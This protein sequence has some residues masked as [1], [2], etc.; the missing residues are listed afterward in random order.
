MLEIELPLTRKQE[1]EA[2][3]VGLMMMAEACYD[4]RAAVGLWQRMEILQSMRR[5]RPPPEFLSTH[6]AVSFP[7]L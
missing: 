6:P 4:P 3:Y 2:D 1:I 7:F 5:E